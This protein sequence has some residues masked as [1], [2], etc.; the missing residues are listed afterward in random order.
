LPLGGGGTFINRRIVSSKLFG[1][2]VWFCWAMMRDRSA[3]FLPDLFYIHLGLQILGHHI[4]VLM[5]HVSNLPPDIEM[6]P[7]CGRFAFDWASVQSLLC[8]RAAEEM[9]S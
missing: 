2:F 8:L 5:N 1:E 7:F 4:S 6:N 9:G 3:K